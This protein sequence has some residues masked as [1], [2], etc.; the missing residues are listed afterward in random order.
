MKKIL[1]NQEADTISSWHIF[2]IIKIRKYKNI[3]HFRQSLSND[4]ISII[5]EEIAWNIT[6]A[7]IKNSSEGRILLTYKSVTEIGF[8]GGAKFR[9]ICKKAIGQTVIIDNQEYRVTLCPK[10]AGP[11]ACRECL[12]YIDKKEAVR[13]YVA[14]K[15]VNDFRGSRAIFEFNYN[16]Y[17]GLS[18]D[19]EVVN[20][21][22]VWNPDDVFIFALKKK[23][24]ASD[25]LPQPFLQFLRSVQNVITLKLKKV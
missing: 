5:E 3:I 24:S 18:L 19:S 16:L 1:L 11:Q 12:N 17:K 6:K 23:I 8:P 13:F 9:A 20:S 10:E 7:I 2:G 15:P 21:Y 25:F 14:M 22:H 4:D